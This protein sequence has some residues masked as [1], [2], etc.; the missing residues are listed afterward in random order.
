MKAI[1]AMVAGGLLAVAMPMASARTTYDINGTLIT[2]FDDV[3]ATTATDVFPGKDLH[4]GVLL[5]VESADPL[6]PLVGYWQPAGFWVNAPN[7]PNV[8]AWSVY[9]VGNIGLTST[10][11]N[12]LAH[13]FS[14]TIS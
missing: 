4:V 11:A 14:N 7:N 3:S 8:L 10:L 5:D 6:A 9:N 1:I 2:N 12:T 13:H